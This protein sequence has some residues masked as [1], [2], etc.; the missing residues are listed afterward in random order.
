LDATLLD[1]GTDSPTI[2]AKASIAA[3]ALDDAFRRALPPAQLRIV[4]AYDLRGVVDAKATVTGALDSPE[5]G[6]AA[7]LAKGHV[8][9]AGFVDPED[10]KRYGFAYDVDDVAGRVSLE[11]PTLRIDA[12]GRHGPASVL[13]AGTVRLGGRGHDVPD[14]TIVAENVPL[15]ASVRDAFNDGGAT[16][17]TPWVPSGTAAKITVRVFNDAEIDGSHDAVDVT[18]DLDG[19]ASFVPHVFPAALSNV[20]GRVEVLEAAV[21][22]RRESLVRLTDLA[23]RGDGFEVRVSGDVRGAGDTERED[24]KI[25]ADVAQAAGPFREALERSVLPHGTIEAVKK[26]GPSGAMRIDAHVVRNAD[27]TRADV[28]DV[29]LLGAAVEGYGDVPLAAH[30]LTGRV[31]LVGDT[32]TFEEIAGEFVMGEFAPA[33]RASGTLAE[34][35]GEPQPTIHVEASQ[36]P[37]G[38]PLRAALGPL[39]EKAERFWEIVGPVGSTRADLVLDLR[40]DDDP[41][42]FEV[43]L[44][45]MHGALRP[46]G[47]EIDCDGGS[48]H[49]D[50]RR[51]QMR[52]VDSA[53][54]AATL[55]FESVDYDTRSG[56]VDIRISAMRALRF[57]EDLEGPLSKETVDKIAAEA[58][59][60]TMH[61]PELHLVYRPDPKSLEI[62]GNLVFRPRTRKPREDE[63]YA[64]DGALAVERL[65]FMTPDEGVVSFEGVARAEDF[66]FRVGLAIDRF[67]GKVGLSGRLGETPKFSARTTGASFRVEEFPFTDADVEVVPTPIGHRVELSRAKF[68]GGSFTGKVGTGEK[69]AGYQG[70]FQLAGA[71]LERF[72]RSRGSQ[73]D[74]VASGVVDVN[75]KFRNPTG[76]KADLRGDGKIE[77]VR[78]HLTPAPGLGVVMLRFATL[79][80]LVPELTEGEMKFDLEGDRLKVT[81]LEVKSAGV[82]ALTNGNGWIDLGG[83]LDVSVD[84]RLI[85]VDIPVVRHILSWFQKPFPTRVRVSGTLRNPVTAWAGYDLGLTRDEGRV[86]PPPVGD[87]RTSERDPW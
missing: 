25:R 46:L 43:E 76:A 75:L 30:K 18:L 57:P 48:F 36:V 20:S 78:G 32:L 84:G 64:P 33:F 22:G 27:K 52:G 6:V 67:A 10:G 73:G 44:L 58:P 29:A 17:F 3:L 41:T 28:V 71:D 59:G 26:L 81:K 15:D 55:R 68:M 50:G 24:L 85:D 5:V 70:H 34:T 65:V 9:Y 54:A 19:R 86:E 8:R 69:G 13:C 4:E 7:T 51:A 72:L 21:D 63:G 56:V 82:N 35:S 74:R 39:G 37:L 11:G 60:R 83:R 47:L 61:A 87:V 53:I 12:E 31:K 40:P 14:L 66:A 23:A 45:G 38:E 2:D 1:I 77:V 16:S 79:G 62:D 49:Y 80:L 42:P